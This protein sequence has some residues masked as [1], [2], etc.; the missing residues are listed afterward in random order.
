MDRPVEFLRLLGELTTGAVILNTHVA[1]EVDEGLPPQLSVMTEHEGV[2]GRWYFE[3]DPGVLN[4]ET[5]ERAKWTS[6]GNSRSFWPTSAALMQEL[7]KAGF[8]MVFESGDWLAPDIPAGMEKPFYAS[9]G[10]RMIVG[11][12]T[13]KVR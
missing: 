12:R 10:R 9:L 11:I 1:T 6:W 3:Y 13:Q 8:D 5:L 2:L 7:W 4:V